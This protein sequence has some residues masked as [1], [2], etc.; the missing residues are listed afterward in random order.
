[1]TQPYGVKK[2][3]VIFTKTIVLINIVTITMNFVQISEKLDVIL[4]IQ[5]LLNVVIVIPLLMVVHIIE[6]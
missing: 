2:K 5:V 3:D 1:M 4:N 6:L